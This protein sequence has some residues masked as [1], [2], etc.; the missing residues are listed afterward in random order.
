MIKRIILLCGIL[1]FLT[2]G[3]SQA[4]SNITVQ[5]LYGTWGN[6]RI[7]HQ[8]TVTEK[9]INKAWYKVKDLKHEGELTTIV[10][11]INGKDTMTFIFAD[12]N[13]NFFKVLVSNPRSNF[14]KDGEYYQRQ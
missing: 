5:T 14:L 8:I 6:L 4:D 11:V 10:L 13:P 12:N 7:D 3:S 2:M 9:G 1:S